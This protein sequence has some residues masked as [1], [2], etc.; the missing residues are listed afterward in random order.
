MRP[1]SFQGYKRYFTILDVDTRRGLVK[2]SLNSQAKAE[3]RLSFCRQISYL[4]NIPKNLSHLFP[5]V[6]DANLD[7]LYPYIVLELCSGVTASNLFTDASSEDKHYEIFCERITNALSEF[8]SYRDENF[9]PTSL[10]FMYR[11]KAIGRLTDARLDWTGESDELSQKLLSM[12]LYPFRIDQEHVVSLLEIIEIC[13]EYV[14]EEGR[15]KSSFIFIHGDLVFT[16]ILYDEKSR[17]IKLIDPRGSFGAAPTQFGDRMYDV[18]KLAQSY[19]GL[20]DLILDGNYSINDS[21]GVKIGI[22]DHIERR[23]KIAERLIS[24]PSRLTSYIVVLLLLSLL[25][26]H[27]DSRRN[28]L[29]FALRAVQIFQNA[30][31]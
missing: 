23:K 31:R 1:N 6:F 22:G 18:G 26:L 21:G 29:A 15:N 19:M 12:S 25:P 4:I 17:S 8:R 10:Q 11:D 13:S 27:R 24:Q 30:S 5:K 9:D 20:Y 14:L 2:K 28:Q 16:N 3:E 7:P